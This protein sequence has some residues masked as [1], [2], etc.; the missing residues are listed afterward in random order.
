M[1]WL[2]SCSA[3]CS[4]A[5]GICTA[6][7]SV[8][9]VLWVMLLKMTMSRSR[10]ILAISSSSSRVCTV[11]NGLIGSHTTIILVRGLKEARTS[12]GFRR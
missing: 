9:C 3:L 5:I 7:G 6:L 11:P 2:M 12:S 1:T 4:E 8:W 10:A